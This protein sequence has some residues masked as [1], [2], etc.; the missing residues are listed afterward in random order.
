M[1]NQYFRCF[2]CPKL[3]KNLQTLSIFSKYTA[4]SILPLAHLFTAKNYWEEAYQKNF[5]NRK[6][7]G[8]SVKYVEDSAE[9]AKVQSFVHNVTVE[10]NF[11]QVVKFAVNFKL[12]GFLLQIFK[13]QQQVLNL[14]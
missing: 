6:H 5:D 14:L 13:I 9:T 10:Q 2:R 11:G 3:K 7:V 1:L 12:K 4:R 8:A